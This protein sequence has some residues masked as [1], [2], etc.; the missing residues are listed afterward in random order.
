MTLRAMVL[1]AGHGS[2]LL[3]LTRALA[4]PALPFVGRAILD[5]VL[6]GLVDAGVE[7][8]IVNLHHAPASVRDLV[9]AR[10]TAPPRVIWSDETEGLLGTGG[11]LMPVR[12]LFEDDDFLLV[13][14]DC[15]HSLSYGALLADHRASGASATLAVLPRPAADFGVLLVDESGLVTSF[16]RPREGRPGERHFL[17][18]QV[19]S[20]SLL[21]TLPSGPPRAFGSFGEWYPRAAAE[22]HVFRAFEMEAEWH[23]VDTRDRYLDATR[24]WLAVRGGQPLV[25]DGARVSPAAR[26]GE[27]CAIHGG[28]VVERSAI[29]H[30]T[31]LL[32]GAR[33]GEAAEL[34]RCLVGPG[35]EVPAGTRH[36]ES[37]LADES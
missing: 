32:P 27:G 26:I 17:S 8:A 9:E 20:P 35:H 33:V 4:K 24:Q 25:E 6:D 30:E 36:E 37:V 28:C 14:G 16:G 31:V 21:T 19:V 5:R 11:A 15:I 7:E 23:A 29:L 12:D 2:R 22:G 18:A 1:A 10:G 3:P 34:R 13:N